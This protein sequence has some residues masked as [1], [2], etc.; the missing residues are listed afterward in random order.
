VWIEGAPEKFMEP[1]T[2]ND[3]GKERIIMNMTIHRNKGAEL[4]KKGNVNLGSR[5][6]LKTKAPKCKNLGGFGKLWCFYNI[7]QFRTTVLYAKGYL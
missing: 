4:H 2:G 1:I 7:L 5:P 6:I 3:P